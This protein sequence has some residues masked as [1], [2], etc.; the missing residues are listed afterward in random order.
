MRTLFLDAPGTLSLRD[1]PIPEP[2]PG[3]LLV[4]VKAATTCGTDLKAF[5][6]GHPKIPMPGP[7]GH[8]YSGVVEAAG[9]GALF[10]EGEAVMGVHSAPCQRCFWCLRGQENLCDSIMETMVLGSFAEYLLVPE[11]IARLNVFAKPDDLPF[12]QASLLEPLASVAQGVLE[13]RKSGVLPG[14]ENALV[15]GPGAIGLMWLAAL[16]AE[17]VANVTVAGRNAE[18]LAV[19]EAMGARAESAEAIPPLDPGYDLVIEATGQVSIWESSVDHARRGGTVVL[20]G[21][22]PGGTSASF[23]THRLHYDQ[24]SLLSPFHFGTEAVRLSRD[25]LTTLDFSPLVSGE[26][27]LEEAQS[28]FTD[29]EAG[30]GIKYAFIP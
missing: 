1:V 13:L 23:N 21:G 2:G 28:T 12:I 8:E 7:F 20:F 17:G 14:A 30:R 16:K 5:R 18:R 27:S 6:R 11:R 25:W 19:A 15:I 26:R 10:R 22:P 29:L 4:R 24:I 9:E 3:E